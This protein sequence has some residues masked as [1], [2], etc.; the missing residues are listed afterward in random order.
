MSS[1][2]ICAA[3]ESDHF[4]LQGYVVFVAKIGIALK[5]HQV[6]NERSG[7]RRSTVYVHEHG[8]AWNTPSQTR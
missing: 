1:S 6:S 2:F 3:L 5:A 8:T 4:N 7:I